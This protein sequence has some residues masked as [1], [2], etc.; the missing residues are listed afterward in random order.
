MDLKIFTPEYANTLSYNVEE[1]LNQYKEGVFIVP[2]G[3]EVPSHIVFPD[4]LLEKMLP[5]A[6]SGAQEEYNAA[7][8]LYEAF[9][10]LT[11]LQASYKPFWLH[12]S[13]VE[14]MD[15]MVARWPKVKDASISDEQRIKVVNAHWFHTSTIRNQLEG[16]Y[17][18]VRCSVL[19]NEDGSPDY[20][21]TKFLFSRTK[22]GNR[23]VGASFLFRNP[24]AVKGILRFY[25]ENEETLL[26]PAFEDKTDHCIQ[27]LNG[28]GAVTELSLWTED[29]FYNFLDSR[30]EEI[31]AILDRKVQ[32]RLDEENSAQEEDENDE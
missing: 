26:T 28:K 19:K 23:G 16:L 6:V 12:L 7:I 14:L 1:N 3:V 11:P 15:Y 30:R 24:N 27:L 31:G 5:Y 32:K 18:L 17:W 29:D 25:I 9:K 8:A 13:H 2:R 22:L 10:E 21:Y 20:T 4:D